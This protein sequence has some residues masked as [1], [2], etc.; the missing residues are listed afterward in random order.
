MVGRVGRGEIKGV[1][2][3]RDRC[4]KGRGAGRQEN[5]SW[6]EDEN[7]REGSGMEDGSVQ[8]EHIKGVRGK[9]TAAQK[10]GWY[11]IMCLMTKLHRHFGLAKALKSHDLK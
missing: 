10:G 2:R 5:T 7:V 3:K 11:K 6:P 9:L 4:T 1:V 8:M